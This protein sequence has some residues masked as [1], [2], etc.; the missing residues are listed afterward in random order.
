MTLP[1]TGKITPRDYQQ[2]AYN[3]IAQAIRE[4]TGPVF[5]EAS[6]GAGKTIIM[7]MVLARVR[8]MNRT[9]MVLARAGELVEQNAQTFWDCEVNNS[10]FSASLG[11]KSTHYP[12]IVGTEGT[13][14][15]ALDAGKELADYSCDFLLV[16]EC[17]VG[18]SM[19]MTEHGLMRID[20]EEIK[21]TRIYCINEKTG[22]IELDY[23]VRVFSNG[24]RNVSRITLCDGST[25]EC[26]NTHK[27]LSNGSWIRAKSIHNGMSLTVN[28]SQD[29]FMKKLFRAAAAVAK[30][31]FRQGY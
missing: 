23:P 31:L 29:N 10:I 26:T 3:A 24:I 16:D 25:L 30:R 7:G 20:S 11:I 27:L 5:I 13:V 4:Y 28:A 21:K 1:A 15:N 19:I 6:V 22:D 8:E 17:L 2:D 18:G 14:V 9:A 12:V